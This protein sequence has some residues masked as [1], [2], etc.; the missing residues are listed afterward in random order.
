MRLGMPLLALVGALLPGCYGYVEY[1]AT[2]V[3]AADV[4]VGDGYP[5]AYYNGY[6]VFYDT[7]GRPFYYNRGAPVWVPP[8]S[9]YY[10][11]LVN[12]WQVYRPAYGQWYNHY[13]YR[14][15]GYR[16]A[17]GYNSYYGYHGYHR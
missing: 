10:G 12:H 16:T 5:P 8:A 13:G 3:T 17:P 9:P 2:T 11:G 14:Y 7:T 15:R 4:P 6:V 1:P